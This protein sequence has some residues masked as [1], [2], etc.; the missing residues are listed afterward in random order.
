MNTKVVVILFALLVLTSAA[1]FEVERNSNG[2][3]EERRNKLRDRFL[4]NA[5]DQHR[6]DFR[7]LRG[8]V[9][10][11]NYLKARKHKLN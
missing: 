4:R 10:K 6:L 2:L 11:H 1:V 3:L 9:E 7:K 8:N 5:N